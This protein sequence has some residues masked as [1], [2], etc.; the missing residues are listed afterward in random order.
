MRPTLVG[1]TRDCSAS[2][3]GY[4]RSCHGTNPTAFELMTSSDRA[5]ALFYELFSGLPRQGPGT[6]AAST[7]RA[8][9]LVPDVGP[10]TRVLDIGCGT[11][12]GGHFDETT[13]IAGLSHRVSH[14]GRARARR[15]SRPGRTRHH[16]HRGAAS[17]A[18]GTTSTSPSS[19]GLQSGA[20]T[21]RQGIVKSAPSSTNSRR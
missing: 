15:A 20:L 10:R 11:G 14:R 19:W 3:R 9:G 1:C 13:R 7:R 16:R 18:F 12:A 21:P 5:T 4:A 17:T 6:T 2:R 8:L